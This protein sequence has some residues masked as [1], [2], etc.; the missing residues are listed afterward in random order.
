MES[1]AAESTATETAATKATAT[2]ATAPIGIIGAMEVEC[3]HLRTRLDQRTDETHSGMHTSAGLLNDVPVVVV[4]CGVG[5]VNAAI[6]VQMLVDVFGVR[7]L[8]NSGIA[9]SLKHGIGL[10]DVVVS[11]D[12]VQHDMDVV[13][14]GYKPGQVPGMSQ[15]FKADANLANAAVA[16]VKEIAPD[17]HVVR[18]RIA[19][20]QM[21]VR[22][23]AM[24]KRIV[25]TFDADCCEMEGAAI[26]Q[27][28]YVN[29]VPFVI[30]RTISD[31][32]NGESSMAY[33]KFEK[34]AA[35]RAAKITA[36]LVSRI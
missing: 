10:L 32:A 35:D 13:N 12:A 5:Q 30:V 18:G 23:N 27:A 9:G 19:S 29:K 1:T 15:T 3:A 16:A 4:Q 11:D 24:K 21:F 36:S 26:A 31:E 22:D 2:D 14:L 7:Y 6:C 17:S 20:G 33:P 34:I 25:D 8:I 28:A